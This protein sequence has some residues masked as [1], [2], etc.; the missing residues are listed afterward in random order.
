MPQ[1]DRHS[2]TIL[3]QLREYDDFLESLRTI[4]DMGC[5]TGEDLTWF[6]TLETRD[7]NPIP[8]NYNC[9]AVD[10]DQSKLNKVPD[11]TNIRK[12]NRDFTDRNILPVPVDL[13]LSHDSLQ[14]SHNPLETL[15]IWNEMMNVNGMLILAVP[16]HSGVEYNRYYSR[17]YNNCLYHFTP[18]SLIYLLAVNGF[19]CRDAYLLKKFQDPWIHIAVY[20]S[21]VA[22]MDPRTTTWFDL[23]DK[24]LL[25]PSIVQSITKH[26]HLRQEEIVMPWL[27]K[28]NYY[29]DYV[30]QWTDIPTEAEQRTEGVVNKI[31]K[32]EQNTIEQ[33][34]A[35]AKKT[36]TLKPIGVMR[37][38]K[39]R[40]VK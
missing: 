23:A 35:K 33:A 4:C 40:Y 25:H 3:N 31:I 1:L 13:I 37:A 34:P 8:Y 28:E 11:L 30:P 26:G 38:P 22:P 7:E 6:A 16:Q 2:L 17:S 10:K 15:T 27:D 20:K 39:E 5:G 12:I 36:E 21:D 9:F 14:Y 32:S 29:I 18:A 19:D 24:N